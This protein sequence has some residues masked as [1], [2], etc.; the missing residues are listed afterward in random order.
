MTP[1]ELLEALLLR[2]PP[3]GVGGA[4]LDAIAP[5]AR[6]GAEPTKRA[7]TPENVKRDAIQFEAPP[8]Q[9]VQTVGSPEETAAA[10]AVSRE[11]EA[12][13][14]A[15]VTAANQEEAVDTA[16]H[17]VNEEE[18]VDS[19][20]RSAPVPA[21]QRGAATGAAAGVFTPEEIGMLQQVMSRQVQDEQ[22]AE[23]QRAA[24]QTQTTNTIVGAQNR[25]LDREE[26]LMAERA[27]LTERVE[28]RLNLL[29]S[30]LQRS[31]LSQQEADILSNVLMGA[32]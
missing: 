28:E 6:T 21:A 27:V 24:L 7:R 20:L 31:E 17:A 13:V 22:I 9:P 30:L 32:R 1:E 12:S 26:A 14:D 25:I 23:M 2:R 11:Q 10:G 3:T 16:V 5:G 18:A 8:R 29:N 4:L 15:A 19:A